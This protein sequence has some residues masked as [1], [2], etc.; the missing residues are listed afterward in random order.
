MELFF[1]QQNFIFLFYLDI[2][3]LIWLVWSLSLCFA[4]TRSLILTPFPDFQSWVHEWWFFLSQ[5]KKVP[6]NVLFWFLNFL[7]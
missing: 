4:L 5:K 2:S 3:I 7:N 1:F 6:Y